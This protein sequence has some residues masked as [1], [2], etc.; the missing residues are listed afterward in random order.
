MRKLKEFTSEYRQ[1]GM[2]AYARSL[3]RANARNGSARMY[4]LG[5]MIILPSL[6]SAENHPDTPGKKTLHLM[7]KC[8]NPLDVH[9][10]VEQ[11]AE[12]LSAGV[13][14]MV[15]LFNSDPEAA[16]KTLLPLG[17][18][19]E[20]LKTIMIRADVPAVAPQERMSH[21]LL[22]CPK[23][24]PP[25]VEHIGCSYRYLGQGSASYFF[26]VENGGKR[27]GHVEL[28]L[29]HPDS[30]Y[31]S[32]LFVHKAYRRKGVGTVLMELCHQ[33]IGDAGIRTSYLVPTP[34]ALRARIYLKLGYL[35]LNH[36][37]VLSLSPSAI[38]RQKSA[39]DY[40]QKRTSQG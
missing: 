27:I 28:T 16:L 35:H 29:R 12:R 17:Y 40:F 7:S 24:P 5:G 33:T 9:K 25:E 37:T 32:S 8:P 6:T 3:L 13:S 18:H 34:L 15:Y 23:T 2:D 31:I 4:H 19:L 26:F 14:W 20:N 38:P 10:V 39:S 1:G 11:Y 36:L 30:A 22:S 21:S